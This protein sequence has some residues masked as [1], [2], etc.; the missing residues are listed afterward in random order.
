MLDSSVQTGIVIVAFH[1][2]TEDYVK[3]NPRQ[4]RHITYYHNNCRLSKGKAI[5]KWQI[6]SNYQLI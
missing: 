6:D 1:I 2:L 5:K 3:I 4:E